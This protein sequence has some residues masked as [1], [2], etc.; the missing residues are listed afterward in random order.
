MTEE[1][2]KFLVDLGIKLSTEVAQNIE[3][4]IQEIVKKEIAKIDN[5]SFG[6]KDILER[7]TKN[8]LPP[9]TY[10]IVMPPYFK[11]KRTEI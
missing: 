2:T 8:G 9:G 11:D 4:Q 10:G 7:F 6:P 3:S 1:K 5:M